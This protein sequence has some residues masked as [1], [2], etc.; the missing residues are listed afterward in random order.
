MHEW[1]YLGSIINDFPEELGTHG[2]NTVVVNIALHRA[3]FA[4]AFLVNPS[5]VDSVL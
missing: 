3:S 5:K 4:L 1:A 2:A